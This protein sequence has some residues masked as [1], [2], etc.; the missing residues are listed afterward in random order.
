M[1]VVW[2]YVYD[3]DQNSTIKSVWVGEKCVNCDNDIG[4]INERRRVNREKKKKWKIKE[5]LNEE[6]KIEKQVKE[7]K[8]R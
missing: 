2:D 6:D 3:D 1:V 4:H 5:R 8:K 7:N